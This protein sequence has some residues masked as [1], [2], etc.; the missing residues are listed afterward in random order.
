[1]TAA[2]VRCLHRL[3]GGQHDSRRLVGSEKHCFSCLWEPGIAV[4]SVEELVASLGNVILFLISERQVRFAYSVL[5]A[6]ND[7]K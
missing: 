1:M 4:S 6:V 3:R 5:A 2:V 7:A